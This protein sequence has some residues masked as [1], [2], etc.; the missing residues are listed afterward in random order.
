MCNECYKL[1]Q[2][3]NIREVISP[4]I[5]IIYNENQEY[6]ICTNIDRYFA[7]YIF[8]KE[9]IKDKTGTVSGETLGIY[10]NSKTS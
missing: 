8:R 6:R 9:N 1:L 5:Y 2:K 4:K 7:E 3:E 10:L